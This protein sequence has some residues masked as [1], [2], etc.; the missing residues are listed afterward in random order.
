[1]SKCT[2]TFD[3]KIF[4]DLKKE[5][6]RKDFDSIC[7]T[8]AKIV[9]TSVKASA[10]SLIPG[11]SSDIINSII[12]KNYDKPGPS[13][14]FVLSDRNKAFW[15]IFYEYGT[16]PRV[17]KGKVLKSEDG[18]YYGKEVS[19]IRATHFFQRGVDS[20]EK[21]ALEYMEREAEKVIKEKLKKLL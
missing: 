13:N 1:M 4:E 7:L 11:D 17:A 14:A 12:T 19:P 8:A 18:T 3:N 10:S 5:V 2:F 21:E 15:N 9:E 20:S 16:G 6:P